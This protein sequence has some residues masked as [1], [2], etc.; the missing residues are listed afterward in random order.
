MNSS[1]ADPLLNALRSGVVYVM[2]RSQVR[3]GQALENDA[4]V[5]T[6][7]VENL[8]AAS[9][10]PDLKELDDL[11]KGNDD[12]ASIAE[13]Q[14]EEESEDE[15]GRARLDASAL[16]EYV[17]DTSEDEGEESVEVDE[18]AAHSVPVGADSSTTAESDRIPGEGNDLCGLKGLDSL[19]G[20]EEVRKVMESIGLVGEERGLSA[21]LRRRRS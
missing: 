7:S 12:I 1:E 6:K 21:R 4:R 5:T 19:K 16:E 9:N 13:E 17:E 20:D 3:A 18:S 8:V 14:Q 11:A 2:T 10:R 15:G